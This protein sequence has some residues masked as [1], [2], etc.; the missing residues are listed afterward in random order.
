MR[1]GLCL[2]LAG[3]VGPTIPNIEYHNCMS[4]WE[5]PRGTR[6][7]GVPSGPILRFLEEDIIFTFK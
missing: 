6:Y 4:T 1:K 7:P 5:L 2:P 3:T